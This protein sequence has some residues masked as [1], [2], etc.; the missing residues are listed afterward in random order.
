MPRSR[1][2]RCLFAAIAWIAGT[3]AALAADGSPG[4]ATVVRIDAGRTEAG[5][6]VKVMWLLGV[7]GQFRKVEGDVRLDR[8]R[9]TLQVEARIDA[10]AVAMGSA[11]YE[12]W[13]RSEDFFDAEHHPQILF[14]SDPF[15]RARL[16]TGGDLPGH[17]T[18][19]G[20]RQDVRFD[21]LP[22]DC[23]RPAYDCPIR[24]AGT[25]RRSRFGMRA[26]RGTLADKVDLD[27]SVYALPASESPAPVPP[28]PG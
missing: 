3:G 17:L 4:Q 27:F 23:D 25:L 6:R 14:S 20:V 21:V 15:P 12:D 2:L 8:F 10:R 9:N 24:V 26:H 5:F 16:L 11:T 28:S 18:L 22:A 7:R 19:R 1:R 13:V